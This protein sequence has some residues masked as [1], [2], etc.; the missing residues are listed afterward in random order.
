MPDP[1]AV[2]SV[3]ESMMN[4]NRHLFMDTTLDPPL[5]N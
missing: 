3:I 1:Q 4:A 5:Q 2:R